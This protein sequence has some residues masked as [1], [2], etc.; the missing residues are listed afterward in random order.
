MFIKIGHQDFLISLLVTAF[1]TFT[2]FDTCFVP[3]FQYITVTFCILKFQTI[4]KH[5]TLLVLAYRGYHYNTKGWRNVKWNK[6]DA[7]GFQQILEKDEVKRRRKR[8]I[9][10]AVNEREGVEHFVKV[11]EE[12]IKL[13]DIHLSTTNSIAWCVSGNSA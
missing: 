3:P 11:L 5:R 13:L 10:R 2:L 8:C 6:Y 1:K 9:V 12:H 7:W 4:D